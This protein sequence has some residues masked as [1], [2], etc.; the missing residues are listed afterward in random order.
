MHR[1]FGLLVIL[2]GVKIFISAG[3]GLIRG[4]S[5]E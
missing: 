5:L 3:P 4:F 2:L 1:E